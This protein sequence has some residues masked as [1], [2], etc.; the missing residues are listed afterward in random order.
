[1]TNPTSTRTPPRRSSRL[2]HQEVD[3]HPSRMEHHSTNVQTSRPSLLRRSRATLPRTTY[4]GSRH[5][6]KTW[7]PHYAPGK[8]LLAYRSR[9]GRAE[10]V[11]HRTY[12][13]GLHSSIQEPLRRPLLFHQKERRKTST[14]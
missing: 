7:G 4:L 11:R 6:P 9:T 12:P 3:P 13:K 14:R 2:P 1:M 8:N 10:E 5:R